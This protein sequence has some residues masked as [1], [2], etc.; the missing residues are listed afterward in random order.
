M[1]GFDDFIN[2]LI[3]ETEKALISLQAVEGSENEKALL[4]EVQNALKA[5]D[6]DA[7][8]KII[9]RNGNQVSQ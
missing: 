7:L 9:E 2:N 8:N 5:N 3:H 6:I 1:N 4:Q